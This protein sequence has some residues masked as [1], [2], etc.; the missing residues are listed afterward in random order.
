MTITQADLDAMVAR[1]CTIEGE[2]NVK[3]THH[4]I[5]AT[6]ANVEQAFSHEP[7]AKKEAQ[8]LDRRC[9]ITVLSKRHRLAD[10]GGTSSKYIIDAIVS[11][12]ILADDSAKHVKEPISETQEKI[13]K[14]Q[15]EET[16]ITLEWEE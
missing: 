8:R 9:R 6:S 10:P 14:N 3:K 15:A 5:S 2:P 13:P 1:G 4:H 12:G 11:A 16:I 7:M